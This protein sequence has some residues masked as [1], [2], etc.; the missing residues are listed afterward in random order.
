MLIVSLIEF[1]HV[2]S[3]SIFFYTI[4]IYLE[5]DTAVTTQLLQRYDLLEAHIE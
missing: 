3:W 4:S 5:N 2:F 1:F